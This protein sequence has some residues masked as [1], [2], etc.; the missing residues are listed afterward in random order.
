M[1]FRLPVYIVWLV[2]FTLTSCGGGVSGENGDDPFDSGSDSD[3]ETLS[4]ALTLSIFDEQC[5]TSTQSFTSGEVVC[6]QATL[7]QDGNPVQSEI[8]TFSGSLGSLSAS[9]K[10]TNS[11]GIAQI[12]I[13]NEETDLGA[14]VLS[15]SFSDA[16]VEQN[17]EYLSGDAVTE[18]ATSIS[19]VM[20]SNGQ[21]INRFQADSEIQVQA[22]IRDKEDAP[23][24]N[25]VV[26]FTAELGTLNTST[27]LTDS[28]GNAQVT[29]SATDSDIGAGV[30][31]ISAEVNNVSLDATY[32]YEVQAS[33][34]ITQ[35]IVRLGYFDDDSVF[36][37]NQLGVTLRDDDGDIVLSAGGT[38]GVSLTLVDENDLPILN[39]TPVTFSSDCVENDAATIDTQV[40][41]V[42]G[43]ANSTYED[44]SCAGSSGTS[45]T[46]IA[47]V[48][49]NNSTLSVSQIITIQAESIGS[50]SF[51][52]A[53][54][55]EI[56]LRGTG[57]QDSE[58]VS[59]LIFE[60]NGELGNPL[61]QQL[62]TFSLNTETGG[63]ALSSETGLSNS[64]GQVSTRVIAG[65]VPTSV[66][67]TAEVETSS[68]EIM[69]T[70]SDL[71]SVNTGLPDQN[72][73]TL[74]ADD[75]NPEAY[76]INEQ[77]VSITVRMADTFNNPVPDGTTVSFTAE[78]G[79]IDS[80][81]NTVSGTCSVNWFS[82]NPTVPEHR[83]T[84]LATA[85]GHETLFDS[86]G[87]NM[88][89][90]DDGLG[91]NDG[92]D[93]G[94]TTS[95]YGQ[96][97]FVDISEAWRDD[98]EDGTRDSGEI[99]LDYNNNG[100]FD[101]PDNLFNGPQCIGSYCGADT[102]HVR[103]ALVLVTSSS[104]A[105]I[106]IE[107]DSNSIVASNYQNASGVTAIARDSIESF[108]LVFSD[109]AGQPI[110]SGSTIFISSSTGQLTGQT[111]FTMPST[112]RNSASQATF[113][114]VN[115]VSET[116]QATVTALITSPSGVT[117]TA[118]M[119]V[120]LN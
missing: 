27:A 78:G 86:N 82:A 96:T 61:S 73:I 85:I 116:T 49:V 102:M 57:G 19:V 48:V 46:I 32:N 47:S 58:S 108:T 106:D 14:A 33:G 29:L 98:N 25:I 44:L 70:Q 42:N 95:L 51:I 104:A 22:T 55:T 5:A 2:L 83:V 37:E 90:D 67:V 81:C 41:T 53:D 28:D 100:S 120:T 87:N 11:Q 97:G 119:I 92:T 80:N 64:Q 101:G 103:R 36:V 1:S 77:E 91:F 30:A 68:G 79:S 18:Q 76:N 60:V 24:E 72:S 45:D 7:T 115:D 75:L 56:V 84:I 110:A 16:S 3:T 13:T 65:T 52:S 114:L 38:M 8:V 12:T 10:L 26:T 113:N 20:L 6:V 74:S 50:L 93:N 35:D 112:N 99:F 21:G 34:T 9:T 111:N 71:L 107:D 17:Y 39:Q 15:A 4:Y 118:S 117:S 31:T 69:S 94:L 63:L 109:T 89:D 54:P 40:N 43:I 66:R 88:Y 59:T 62:V 23:I 105:Q